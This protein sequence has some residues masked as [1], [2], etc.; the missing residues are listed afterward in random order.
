MGLPGG[1]FEQDDADLHATAVRE[2]REEVGLILEPAHFLGVLD[3]VSPRT[4]TAHPIVVRPFVF[5][6]SE[7]PT[8]APNAEVALALWV[9][10]DELRR[11]EVY[12]ET[13]RKVRGVD[14]RFP[15]YN[16]GEHVVW[17]LTERILTGMLEVLALK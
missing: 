15:A 8:L 5:G 9:D 13:T 4:P 1:R 10:L 2:T 6:I 7:R 11:V 12:R 14:R 16:L 3:D 17:G